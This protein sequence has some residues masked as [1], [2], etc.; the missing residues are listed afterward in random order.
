MDIYACIDGAFH[1]ESLLLNVVIPGLRLIVL[2][3]SAKFLRFSKIILYNE[4]IYGILKSR[5]K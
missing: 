2:S 1:E 5:F 4:K 3:M